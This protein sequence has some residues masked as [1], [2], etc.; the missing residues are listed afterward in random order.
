MK[1][2]ILIGQQVILVRKNEHGVQ[3]GE[4][5]GVVTSILQDALHG[6]KYRIVYRDLVE[7]DL[8]PNGGE[9][10]IIIAD[11]DDLRILSTKKIDPPTR[12]NKF[13][14]G[15]S[16]CVKRVIDHRKQEFVGLQGK[17]S[18]IYMNNSGEYMYNLID[19]AGTEHLGFNEEELA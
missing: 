9:L 1:N 16:V 13:W 17:V 14:I 19:A 4:W 11:D 2:K 7:Q 6:L 12:A 8:P 3:N 15:E 10:E 18:K 5:I